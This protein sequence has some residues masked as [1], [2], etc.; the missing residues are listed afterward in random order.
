MQINCGGINFSGVLYQSAML[1]EAVGRLTR[2][3]LLTLQDTCGRMHAAIEAMH[4]AKMVIMTGKQERNFLQADILFH[5]TH[6]RRH[7]LN[8]RPHSSGITTTPTPYRPDGIKDM[9]GMHIHG[10][11]D[12][13][14]DRCHRGLVERAP[15][16]RKAIAHCIAD[17]A[18]KHKRRVAL[19]L[20]PRTK[21]CQNCL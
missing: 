8:N 5:L 11:M 13:R 18:K 6:L 15:R 17:T 20:N 9:F 14:N 19:E 12:C 7:P 3:G 10:R 16:L 2:K 1:E 21:E 4:R